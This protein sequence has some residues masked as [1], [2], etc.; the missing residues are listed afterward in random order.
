MKNSINATTMKRNIFDRFILPLILVIAYVI[1]SQSASAQVF[2]QLPSSGTGLAN[3]NA[4]W[5]SSGGKL[6]PLATGEINSNGMT[7]RSYLFRQT[8]RNTFSTTKTS[9]PD[10]VHGSLDVADF[11]KNGR[12]DVALTGRGHNNS[13]IA[14]IYLQQADGAF[15]K[16][17]HSI[18]ALSDGSIQFG[19]FDNDGDIDLLICGADAN[20]GLKT[21]ILRN[22]NSRLIPINTNLPGVHFG[23]AVWGDANKNG[24]LDIIITGQ[25][26]AGPITK[27]FQYKNGSYEE[28]AQAFT[29]LK[30]SDVAW[31]DFNKDGIMDFFIAGETRGG[32]PLTTWYKGSGAMRFTEGPRQGMR[33]LMHAS[34]DV[35]DYNSDGFPDIVITGESLERPYSIVLENQKGQGF[36]DL[37]AGLPGVSNGVARFGDYDR[38]GD[39]DIFLAGVDVCYNLLSLVYR[40]TLDKPTEEVESLYVET[41]PMELSRGPYYYFVFSSCYCDPEGTGTKAYHG[42]V[43]NIHQEKQ[44]FDLT[45]QFNHLLISNYPGWNWAD[46]GHRTSNAFISLKDAEEGRKTVIGSYLADKYKVHYINW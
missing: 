31:A 16:S 8:A 1:F 43:S 12:H 17:Q 4:K 19:D 35:G 22:E 6:H 34:V 38:D 32:L 21:I 29:G 11:N 28:I 15:V 10:I 39:P 23:K 5:I 41:I 36:R 40:N 42:F 44:D 27:I 37:V 45:Y 14:G 9:L 13:L 18:P 25:S 7:K 2:T 20:G 3:A 33:Q 26:V 30:H 24:Y 46:R